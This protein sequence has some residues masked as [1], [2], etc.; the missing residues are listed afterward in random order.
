MDCVD[1]HNTTGH[2][3]A[4]TAER[5]VDTAIASGRLSVRLPFIR[6]EAVRL[7]KT[8]Q[9]TEQAALEAIA[10]ELQRAYPASAVA[11]V[12]GVYRA[13]VFPAMKVVPGTYPD[14]I[15]HM[16]SNGCFRCHDGSHTAKDGSS[17]SGDCEYCH[18]QVEDPPVPTAAVPSAN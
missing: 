13:S 8:E 17:I 16:T 11:A 12:Q 7:L 6:R 15:G 4:L 14:N 9:T 10:R 1:C 3:I 5:A 2:R 18:V